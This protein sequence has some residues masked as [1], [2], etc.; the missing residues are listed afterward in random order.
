MR[1]MLDTN[2][3]SDLLRT[4]GRMLQRAC[5]HPMASLC[6]SVIT[7]AE[8]RCG[9][10]KRPGALRLHAAVRKLLLR[11]QPLPWD[12]AVAAVYGTL[13]AWLQAQ[14]RPLNP[15][16]QQIAAHA[17]AVSAVLVTGVQAFAQ[18]PDLQLEDWS[19]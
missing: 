19:Q 5:E 7:K 14:S 1:W 18:V 17:L 6:M 9:L 11:A 3:V 4:K 10:A 16:D 15:L 8:L 2:A 13:R 12:S